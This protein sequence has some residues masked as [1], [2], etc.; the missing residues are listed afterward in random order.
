MNIRKATYASHQPGK[1]EHHYVAF[2]TQSE[3][4]IFLGPFLNVGHA[5]STA[6]NIMKGKKS[7]TSFFPFVFGLVWDTEEYNKDL[8][9]M[10][11]AGEL[12][13]CVVLE[14]VPESMEELQGF[15]S[16]ALRESLP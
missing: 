14:N 6:K 13:G 5:V 1:I 11:K 16:N 9:G 8:V 10:A 3:E 12:G 2:L 4:T 7:S 15:A